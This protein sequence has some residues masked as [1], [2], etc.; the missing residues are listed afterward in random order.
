MSAGFEWQGSRRWWQ[1]NVRAAQLENGYWAVN[2]VQAGNYQITLRRWPAE[3]NA[4][5]T[6]AVDGGKAIKAVKAKLRIGTIEATQPIATGV[7]AVTFQ[8][9][10]EEGKTRLQTWFIDEA[11][12]SRG[13]FYLEAK[14][15]D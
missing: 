12:E 14:R 15:L 4:S 2:V 6:A 8:V 11:G 9:R 13:A 10:L 1:G 3:L 7:R 5:I